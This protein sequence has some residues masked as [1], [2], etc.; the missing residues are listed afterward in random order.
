MHSVRNIT[1]EV[2]V[3]IVFQTYASEITTE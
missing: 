1:T 3:A 2:R